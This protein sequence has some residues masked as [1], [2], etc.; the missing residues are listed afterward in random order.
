M[1]LHIYT[2]AGM[3]KNIQHNMSKWDIFWLNHL[4]KTYKLSER[5][6]CE[7]LVTVQ[8]ILHVKLV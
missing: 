5:Y 1:R 6:M 8:T 3:N 2:E 7:I 4:R